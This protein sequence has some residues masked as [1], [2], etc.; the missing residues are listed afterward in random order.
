MKNKKKNIKR[1]NIIQLLF[2]IVIILLINIISSF[3]F[4]RFDLTA[5]KRYS[6]RLQQRIY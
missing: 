3:V 6:Y 2:A 5:E 1:S 4:T